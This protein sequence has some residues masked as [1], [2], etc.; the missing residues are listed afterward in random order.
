MPVLVVSVVQVRRMIEVDGIIL[1]ERSVR[2]RGCRYD[3]R[4]RFGPGL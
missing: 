4:L 1:K 3:L 2:W